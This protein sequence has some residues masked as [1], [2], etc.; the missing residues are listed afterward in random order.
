M[1]A[2]NIMR[3]LIVN[4]L[5]AKLPNIQQ[6]QLIYILQTMNHT[7]NQC[8]RLTSAFVLFVLFALP[9]HAQ[10]GTLQ[11][12]KGGGGGGFIGSNSTNPA[13]DEIY[14]TAID[15]DDNLIVFRIHGW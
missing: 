4:Q 10:Q 12:V 14:T 13:P 15:K 9:T 6:I 3:Q 1:V 5:S 11:F 8:L 7:L 2:K